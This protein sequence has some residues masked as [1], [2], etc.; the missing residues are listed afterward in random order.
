MN[1]TITL[2][3]EDK[4]T[5]IINFSPDYDIRSQVTIININANNCSIENLNI[6][7]SN[8]SHFVNSITYNRCCGEPGVTQTTVLLAGGISINSKNTTIK[9]NIITNVTDG[10]Q[11]L[12]YSKSN[13][14]THNEIKNNQIGIETFSSINNNISNNIL[15][16]NSQYNIYLSTDSDT[17]KVSF[18]IMD[19]STY[20][21][22][23]KASLHNNVYKNCIKNNDIGIYC[24]CNA[25]ENHFYSNSL[26][27]N[28]LRNAEENNGLTN[29]WYDYQNATGNYWDN[30]TG[31]DEN[32]DGIGDT[33]YEIFGAG[34]QDIYP[35]MAPPL[36]V[37]CNQ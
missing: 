29:I 26:L 11:L 14:I 17:N 34:N 15:S 20:G 10:I 9:N 32:H 23:I 21:I 13:T 33:P 6:T 22:R 16:N 8:K 28:F 5:T 35:L 3:G 19:N 4:N 37:P 24:C 27:N 1:K 12:A 36:D 30:Y 31:R 2:I 18:N 7:L 25:T